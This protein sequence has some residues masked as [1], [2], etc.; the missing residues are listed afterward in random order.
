MD[1]VNLSKK[2]VAIIKIHKFSARLLYLLDHVWRLIT[3]LFFLLSKRTRAKRLMTTG[4]IFEIQGETEVAV[5]HYERAL[6]VCPSLKE[7][8]LNLCR[9]YLRMLLLNKA[10]SY[11][12]EYLKHNQEDPEVNLYIGVIMYYE[13]KWREALGY[14]ERAVKLFPEREKKIASAQE[15]MA[16]CYL[17]LNEY[18]RAVELLEKV[19]KANPYSGGDRKFVS[20]GEAYYFLG[21][22]EEALSVFKRA[23]SI[24]PD[25]YETWNNI[26]V[27]LWSDGQVEKA[28]ECFRKALTI[29]PDYK[30]AMTN[31]VT[32]EKI[33]KNHGSDQLRVVT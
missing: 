7:I 6:K 22:K 11:G 4:E 5:Q 8:N 21:R 15:Y 31:L 2:E 28:C 19:I 23:L 20:L 32:I 3:T 25:N 29:K 14:L 18:E 12:M 16:E 27:L 24:N 26:G 30:E 17:K 33:L 10:K 1:K 13:K 9:C